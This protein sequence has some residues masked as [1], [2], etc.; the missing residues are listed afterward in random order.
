M[1]ALPYDRN[2]RVLHVT[3]ALDPGGIE[4]WLL[5]VARHTGDASLIHTV[6][7]LG[8]HDGLLAPQF[9]ELGIEVLRIAPKASWAH[10]LRKMTGVLRA[11]GPWDAVHSHVYR[12]GALVQAASAYCGVPLRVTHSHNDNRERSKLLRLLAFPAERA[13]TM[14]INQLSHRRL[15]CSETAAWS[16]FGEMASHPGGYTH[17]PY[18][19]DA[20]AFLD[21]ARNGGV[22]RAGLGI[23]ENAEV[24]G[25]IGRFMPQKNHE[26]LLR[27]AAEA[28][29]LNP[30]LHFLLAGDGPL[31][32]LME[33]LAQSLGI[34]DHV[35][36]TGNRLDIPA[37]LLNCMDCFFFPSRWE[38]LGI[39]MLEA[40]VAGL[41]CFFSDRVPPEANVFP[42]RN[43]RFSP[44]I[45]PREC[46]RQLAAFLADA[47]EMRAS[48]QGRD[49]PGAYHIGH[50]VA[51]LRA[52]YG[53]EPADS[54]LPCSRSYQNEQPA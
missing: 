50:N 29:R 38:G 9:R 6:L 45:A 13:A 34:G 26:Y 44:E 17:L 12:R 39:V 10:F 25:H 31:R 3:S 32:S 53:H 18:G 23:P 52:M 33:G 11:T 27:T 30:R 2:P 15:A 36:F 14:V 49:L 8:D 1:P 41:P 48:K 28:L 46:A 4:T 43:R 54:S 16:L 5:R 47:K 37:L 20:A 35:T 19:M 21:A 42:E 22:N 7:V 40:Q 51:V 24:I